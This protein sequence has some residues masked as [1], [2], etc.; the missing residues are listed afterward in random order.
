MI[1]SYCS[2]WQHRG[3]LVL[4]ILLAITE[5][6]PSRADS[7]WDY[8]VRITADVQG[9]PPQI[10]LTWEPDDYGANSFTI[11]RKSKTATSW[12]S[13]IAS[14]SGTTLSY[15]D[16][17]VSVGTTYE[18]QI[19]EAST[20]GYTSY[21][22]IYTGINAPLTE[23]RGKM[24]LVVASESSVGL[25]NELAQLRS[26]LVGDGWQVIRHD[27]SSSDTPASVRALIIN[28][29]NA[30]PQ[31]VQAV[32]LFGHVPILQSGFLNYDLHIS[33]PMP[34]DGFYADMDGDWSSSPSYIPSDLELM[35]GR[36]DLAN[37]PGNAA[38]GTWPSETELLR[39]YLNKDHKWRFKQINAP[40]RALLA[41]RFG[42][43]DGEARAATGF[44]NLVPFVGHG[45]IQQ[46][47]ISDNA[48]P[49]QRW[50]SLIS[51]NRYLWAY[52]CGGGQDTSISELGLHGQYND[53]WTTDMYSQDAKAVF[54]ML[55]GSWFGNWDHT[56]NVMRA[57]LATPSMGLACCCIAGHPHWYIHHMG[58]GEPIGYGAR[59]TMNNSTLYR[60][61]TNLFTRAIYITLLGDP[62][63][64]MEPVAPVSSLAAGANEG[65][66]T[67]NWAPSSESVAGYHVY[68]ATSPAGP[69]TR[70]TSSLISDT[71]IHETLPQGTYTY[72]VRAVALQVNPS[73]S[74]YN[75][76]QG[77]FTTVTVNDQPG[78]TNQAL[79]R[80]GITGK[81][82]CTPNLNNKAPAIGSTHSMTATAA[83]G[84]VFSNWTRGEFSEEVATN[85]RTVRFIMES[86]LWLWAN[87][88]TNP[89]PQVRGTY[90][91]LFAADG[92]REQNSSGFFTMSLN[93]SGVGTGTLRIGNAVKSFTTRFDLSGNAHTTIPQAGTNALTLRLSMDLQSGGN[94]V[95]G[96]VQSGNNWTANLT[97]YRA[98][99]SALSNPALAYSNRYTVIFFGDAS[100]LPAT[101]VP[102]G[103]GYAAVTVSRAGGATL[104]GKLADGAALTQSVPISERGDWPLYVSLT[105]GKG[106]LYGWLHLDGNPA[107]SISGNLNW[108][109]PPLAAAKVYTN[110]FNFDTTASGSV[111]AA[112]AAGQRV[113]TMDDGVAVFGV[114]TLFTNSVFLTPKDALTNTPPTTNAFTFVLTRTNGLFSGSVVVPGTNHKLTYQGAFLQGQ[115]TG[116]GYVLDAGSSGPALIGTADQL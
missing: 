102:G 98:V 1:L 56:D 89:F 61:N 26:D 24:I 74:Y 20:V 92:T 15:T 9:S 116:R 29:Y 8:A 39:N 104:S 93:G 13:S 72:M 107:T 69:F 71:S 22:Y 113:I 111:Y 40:R 64:R 59:L 21:G 6:R 34:A 79:L 5:S 115:N 3:V 63:L 25:A 23:S 65:S 4:G 48:P 36:V 77:M 62:T 35:V 12:G 7:T 54:F 90:F 73:G 30:D 82:T 57:T 101:A 43:Y 58:L 10:T 38:P 17:N 96:Q 28:D 52:G 55:E 68:R 103:D 97:A 2:K 70:V 66:V 37:M 110:G 87:F 76:S 27:V 94:A 51:A 85:G 105:G 46:A 88:V 99:F 44:R 33:R 50:S 83:A 14:V 67:V 49:D 41:D 16:S 86:N 114:T 11:Y 31:N 80:V 100:N 112:P 106:S 91:G 18:Y 42:D 109:R 53:V 32:F 81:G 75:P 60:N 47:D 45:N 108:I 19:I 84:F 95:S 78:Q